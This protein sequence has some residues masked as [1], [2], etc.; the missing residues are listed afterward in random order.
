[1]PEHEQ[2]VVLRLSDRLPLQATETRHFKTAHD[3]AMYMWG[4]SIGKHLIYKNGQLA[5]LSYLHRSYDELLDYLAG[6]GT[7]EQEI[8]NA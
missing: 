2:Y 6:L 5:Y 3:V 1:M 8:E 7:K 4:R